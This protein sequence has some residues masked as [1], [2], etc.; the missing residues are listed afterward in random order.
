M[1][2]SVNLSQ[3]AID[4]DEFRSPRVGGGRIW[5][6]RYL[7]P[8]I[9]LVGVSAVLV[10]AS[11]DYLFPPK[12]VS[13]VP[14][15]PL[16]A[17]VQLAGTPLFRAAGWIEP[18]PTPIQVAA[19]APG[20]VERLLVIEDQPVNK[21]ESIAELVKDDARLTHERALAELS[22]RQAEL[23]RARSLLD[24]AET[25]LE[26][27]V[28]LD[29]TVAEALSELAKVQ[30]ELANLP[31]EKRRAAARLKLA[32]RNFERRAGLEKTGAVAGRVVAEAQSDFEEAQA[33]IEELEVRS[34]SLKAEETALS[35]KAAALEKQ[36]DL[37]T[38]ERREKREA[39]AQVK[40]AQARIEQAR[41]DA[42]ESKLRLDRM[43]IRAPVDGRVLHLVAHPG[44]RLMPVQG[45][46]Q[47][48]DGTTVVTLYQ[49]ESLQVR[50]DVPLENLPQVQLTQPV[51]I[52]SAAVSSPLNGKVLSFG[53]LAD[54]QKNT[55]EV[56]VAIENPPAVLKPEML[57]DVTFLAAIPKN[58]KR[59]SSEEM[60]LFIPQQLIQTFENKPFVWVADQSD[61]MAQ[62]VVIE[63]GLAGEN[64]LVEVTK[65]LT[66][67]SRVIASG[68]EELEEGT[69]IRVTGEAE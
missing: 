60:Q 64:G 3:L 22:L 47:K 40:A 59:K 11:Y 45:R 24:A 2:K 21:G 12:S 67:G 65:G 42:A 38:D 15:I 17:E 46:H 7:L 28:H 68:F 27:P 19:L 18:R 1:N 52:E 10:W 35:K 43:T 5:F 55:L 14:V 33:L 29:A 4:R 41:I 36:R 61:E 20:V 44:S 53:S 26:Q 34:G 63:T 13:I 9:L 56:K 49:P 31:F 58:S 37:R 48:H 39:D 25:R 8:G 57:M 54:I 66:M 32:R 23:E 69:R 30:T 6:S 16:R 51:R 62:R 50:V